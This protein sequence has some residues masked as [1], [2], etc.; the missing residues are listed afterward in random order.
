M[1][2]SPAASVPSAQLPPPSATFRRGLRE[3]AGQDG[4]ESKP[5]VYAKPDD[6]LAKVGG[7]E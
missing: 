1:A 5:L 4:R 7:G 2:E 6:C 3:Q